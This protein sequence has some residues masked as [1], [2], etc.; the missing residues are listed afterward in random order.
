MRNGASPRVGGNGG[1]SCFGG[2]AY[3][4]RRNRNAAR[5]LINKRPRR[6][7]AYGDNETYEATKL[8]D[9]V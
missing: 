6:R 5:R 2:R 4:T 1:G 3:S 9:L 7:R 8:K